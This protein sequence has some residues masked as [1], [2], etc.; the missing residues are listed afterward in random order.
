MPQQEERIV[1]MRVQK[2]LARAGVA[3]RRRSEDLMTAGRVCVN[4]EV[5]TELGAKVDPRV[6]TVTVDGRE[7]RLTD[8]PVTI[9]LNKPCG[10]ITTMSDPYGRACVAELVP[11]DDY[12][13][14]FPVGRLDT[15]TSG[16]LLF[17]TDGE[18]GNSLLHPRHHVD[19][20]YEACVQGRISDEALQ[21][22][23]DGVELDDGV[24]SPAAVTLVSRSKE[25]SRIT[26]V[27]HEGRT[28][29]VRRMCQKVGHPVLELHR[30]QFGPLT[31]GDLPEGSWRELTKAEVE[32]LRSAPRR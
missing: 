8:G 6:D 13:G 12:P 25:K 9:M 24:T 28:R 19:K 11:S 23:R 3:S 21:T 20:T 17:S 1:P 31:L 15:D 30:A 32:S 4:G 26:L 14:L 18:L 22:L 5:V 10:F 7:V 27:I 16:L 29:Q 2:F